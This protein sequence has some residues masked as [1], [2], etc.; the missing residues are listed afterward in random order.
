MPERPGD[1]HEPFSGFA[2]PDDLIRY[3]ISWRKK[4]HAKQYYIEY[5]NKTLTGQKQNTRARTMLATL[6]ESIDFD[7]EA[8]RAHR[9]AIL[10]LRNCDDDPDFLKLLAKDLQ[11]EGELVDSDDDAAR[12]LAAAGASTKHTMLWIWTANGVYS[13]NA[14]VDKD[15]V[16][17]TIQ[18]L[19]AKAMARKDR[20]VEEA[21]LLRKDMRRCLRSL[22]VEADVWLR[23]A[24]VDLGRSPAYH[25]STRAY[26]L[27]HHTM[28]LQLRDH[29]CNVWNSPMGKTK[30]HIFERWQELNDKANVWLAESQ[31]LLGFEETADKGKDTPTPAELPGVASV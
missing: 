24:D 1:R 8:Y 12:K 2:G 30:R 17:K 26:A 4:Q 6:Q 31:A 5:R 14:S 16:D 22:E 7:A 15:D 28:W 18:H 9:A 13:G 21:E 11:L 29:F 10:K 25:S 19:W 3:D 20:W 23:R 27:K